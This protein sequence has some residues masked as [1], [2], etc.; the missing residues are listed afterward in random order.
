MESSKEQSFLRRIMMRLRSTAGLT[1]LASITVLAA[2]T[3]HRGP[4][5]L[6]NTV[7]T[8]GMWALMSMG[9]ALVFGVM[10]IAHFAIGEMFMVGGLFSFFVVTPLN[11]YLVQ[12]PNAILS[13]VAPLIAILAATL[14]GALIG[15]ITEI[16][17]FRPLRRR[18][19]EQ[20]IMN[21]FLLT[22]GI[23]IIMINGHQLIFGT[24]F[25]G[26][27]NYWNYPPIRAFGTFMSFDRAFVF[28]CSVVVMAGFWIFMKYTM[29]GQAIRA[30]SQD[31]R[32]ALM[33]GVNLNTIQTL[34]MALSCGLAALAGACL[35]FMFP[36]Y[37]TVGIAPLY[38]AWFVVIVVGLGNVAG[39]VVGGFMV[40]MF[41]ILTTIYIG[42][43][44]N[45]VFPSLLIIA[46][47]V[48]KPSGLFGTAVR[49]VLDQ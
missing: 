23:S 43:G 9:L 2:A 7:V 1:I 26:I 41:Q 3:I 42:E 30:V 13:A 35:L 38:N 36:S 19:R 24:E 12:S 31:E 18:S 33:V 48:F 49:G 11:D 14:G 37:P 16:C 34:T 28:A 15:V 10:N 5:I 44:W 46:I 40:A 22:L 25:K 32:G 27:V 4:Y 45:L 47:L 39:T 17:V 20:W 6:V 29:V 8:G 21:T